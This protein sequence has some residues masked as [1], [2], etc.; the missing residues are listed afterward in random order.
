MLFR[1]AVNLLAIALLAI[2]VAGL[3]TRQRSNV[4]APSAG[5]A[6]A[7]G[8]RVP[9][10]SF[11]SHDLSELIADL[12]RRTCVPISIEP[13][14]G[15]PQVSIVLDAAPSTL[16]EDL[17]QI[18]RSTDGPPLALALAQNGGVRIMP[19]ATQPRTLRVYDV[20]DIWRNIVDELWQ[21]EQLGTI[22]V[23]THGLFV[24]SS[25]PISGVYVLPHGPAPTRR[26]IKP[27]WS[28]TLADATYEL[29]RCVRERVTRDD[30]IE[31][32]GNI[33]SI[34]GFGGYLAIYHTAAG[35]RGV[36]ELLAAVRIADSIRQPRDVQGNKP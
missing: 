2:S 19:A 3:L 31:S 17:N 18:L 28:A 30:W 9:A 22:N 14:V 26:H 1:R 29:A 16:G 32:G 15:N 36:E 13:A 7:L 25:G 23:P 20:R 5:G 21:E 6:D 8:V 27:I 34:R 24:P 12:T 11:S 35:H 10:M 4:P 33:A